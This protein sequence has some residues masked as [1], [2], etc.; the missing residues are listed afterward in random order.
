VGDLIEVVLRMHRQIGSFGQVL[1]DQSI[2]VF[3]R[4]A[5]PGRIGISKENLNF[6]SVRQH[7]MQRHFAASVVGQRSQHVGGKPL[8]CVRQRF[9]NGRC[10]GVGKFGKY[11]KSRGAFNERGHRG[12]VAF[13]LDEIGFPVAW[14]GAIFN[15]NRARADGRDVLQNIAALGSRG[16]RASRFVRLPQGLNQL[17]FELAFGKRVDRFLDGFVA[18][19]GV[20]MARKECGNLIG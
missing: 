19:A 7:I 4:A 17:R 2:G 16:A 11:R 8:H 3:I 1:T 12:S 9:Q 14:N 6:E 10:F 5:L 13:A 18:H 20:G 15:L